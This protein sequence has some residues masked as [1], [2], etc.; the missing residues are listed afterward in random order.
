MIKVTVKLEGVSPI[1]YSRY[2]EQ[3]QN[4]HE[5]KEDCDK[6][7]WIEKAHWNKE[8]QAF[9]PPISLTRALAAT[10]KYLGKTI[11]GKG[12][13]TWTK[14]FEAGVMV[15][16]APLLPYWRKDVEKS[17]E[18]YREVILANADGVR[19]SGKRVNRYFPTFPSW[20]TSATFYVVDPAITEESFREHLE[21]AG[22]FNGLGRFRPRNGGFY[23]R[24]RVV[25]MKWKNEK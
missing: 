17:P 21:A 4:D 10:A 20:E 25:D 14:H 6:R 13:A 9:I 19:G 12:K 11:P 5:S 23:G 24:F 15:L 1:S 16:E 3:S 7:H 22:Q 18:I 2:V 8:G